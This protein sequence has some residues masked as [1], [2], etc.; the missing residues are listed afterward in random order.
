MTHINK[1]LINK[2]DI[3]ASSHEVFN[4]INE[5]AG[6]ILL[7]SADSTHENSHF[8]IILSAPLVDITYQNCR[9]YIKNH[10][11]GQV[12]E[13]GGDPFKLAETL[14][15]TAKPQSQTIDN[16]KEFDSLPFIG[17]LAGYFAYDLGR[18]IETLPEQAKVD[19][20]CPDMIV[21]IYD[22]ALIRDNRAQ[23][24]YSVD[25]QPHLQRIDKI[26]S[27]LSSPA[28]ASDSF[29][30]TSEWQANLDE[31]EYTNRISAIKQYLREGDCYQINLAQ[32]FKAKYKGSEWQAYLKLVNKNKAPF[33]AFIRTQGNAILCISPERFIQMTKNTVET[34]PIK[35]TLP[36]GCD[37]QE[38]E[39]LK[40]Q[41][42]RSSKDRAENL[43]IVDLLRN[44]LAKV[45]KA[46]TVKV[47]SLFNIE[48][49]PAV[50]HLVSTVTAELNDDKTVFDLLRGA[51]PGG[52]ITGAPKVRAMEIIEELEPHR[53]HVYCGSIG[54]IDWRKKMDTNI[55]IRT[56]LTADDHIYCW[57]GGGIVYDSQ[58]KDEY[59]ETFD[60]VS[61]I[62]PILANS[63]S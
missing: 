33:S 4:L 5:L 59:K 7:D 27:Q 52:S 41:L 38:D 35:G 30:L 17:G 63:E 56:L 19:F 12:S 24:W 39:E 58:A 1:Y 20:N 43:M 62:L 53:R 61:R 18:T 26:L 31:L 40:Q 16:S 36:R 23:C 8:D 3:H 44:D 21:G 55:C 10:I 29:K 42:K 13:Q 48:S 34:K 6:A 51:F 50:H 32:R 49:F 2:L 14:W 46:G 54:Y 11:S 37:Q 60:K 25:H 45:A 28:K 47:P 22:W 57:A 9:N 15:Q